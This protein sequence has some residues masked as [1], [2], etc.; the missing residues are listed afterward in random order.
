MRDALSMLGCAV[1]VAID[2]PLGSTHPR[3]PGLLYPINYGHVPGT[4]APDGE[5]I[6]AYVFG[7]TRRLRAFR[8]I[9]VAVVER[10]D[11]VECKLV[12][13]RSGLR[14]STRAIREAVRFRERYF[15]IVV[16]REHAAIRR[17]GGR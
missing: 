12:V 1:S 5:E 17:R 2:R 7:V 10:L 9:C 15:W 6:D 13:A 8:G 11:D 4:V 14:P 16:H 3:W